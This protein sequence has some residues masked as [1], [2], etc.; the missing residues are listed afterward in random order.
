M[1][2][3]Q[4]APLVPLSHHFRLNRPGATDAPSPRCF[5]VPQGYRRVCAFPA[6][7]VHTLWGPVGETHARPWLRFCR[8]TPRRQRLLAQTQ[9]VARQLYTHRGGCR[10]FLPRPLPPAAVTTSAVGA[11]SSPLAAAAAMVMAAYR[12]QGPP[13]ASNAA[14]PAAGVSSKRHWPAATAPTLTATSSTQT[15]AFCDPLAAGDPA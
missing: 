5:R 3:M 13:N 1:K 10:P 15:L 6:S 8:D 14:A 4:D 9:E 7:V 11:S 12:C 2:G